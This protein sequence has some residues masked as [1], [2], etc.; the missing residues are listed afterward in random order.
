MSRRDDLVA[1]MARRLRDIAPALLPTVPEDTG[2]HAPG[3]LLDLMVREHGGHRATDSATW[4]LLVALSATYPSSE[5]VLAARRVLEIDGPPTAALWLLDTARTTILSR[6]APRTAASATLRLVD[7]TVLVDVE[8]AL[9]H[10]VDDSPGPDAASTRA[11]VRL[12]CA[13]QRTVPV[14]WDAD[15]RALR[16]LSTAEVDRLHGRAPAGDARPVQASPPEVVVPTG[17]R[18]V[19]VDVPDVRTCAPLAALAEHSDTTL[20]ALGH[21]MLPVIGADLRPEGEP[22]GF[23]RYLTVLKH[24]ARLVALDGTVATQLRG[25]GGALASQGMPAP[26]VTVVATADPAPVA[27]AGARPE[28]ATVRPEHERTSVLCLGGHEPEENHAAVLHAAE[29]L[30][31]TGLDFPLVLV[32]RRGSGSARLHAAVDELVAA[33]RSVSF[34]PADDASALA[35][36]CRTARFVAAPVLSSRGVATASAALGEGIPVLTGDLPALREL[37]DAGGCL[38][39]DPTDDAAISAAMRAL[40]S[41]DGLVDRLRAE[42]AARP[43]RPDEEFASSLWMALT[44]EVSP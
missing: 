32:D 35:A 24:A 6:S 42:A 37:A 11:A 43:P 5:D 44:A 27:S 20:L 22:D 25:F 23:V 41:D 1:A 19:L 16:P 9:K 2:T 14:T 17:S 39:V 7:G 4:L 30:W 15:G 18:L 40:L 26:P 36:L 10:P 21:D 31:R 3:N 29:H 33:G 34:A 8:Q 12:W 13:Q 38:L 28:D